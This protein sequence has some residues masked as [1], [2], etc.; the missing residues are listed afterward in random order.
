[1]PRKIYIPLNALDKNAIHW[2]STEHRHQALGYMEQN[3]QCGG[4]RRAMG[5]LT[6][7][8]WTLGEEELRLHPVALHRALVRLWRVWSHPSTTHQTGIRNSQKRGP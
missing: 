7:C 4:G 2:V 3:A 1:M 5:S 8:W 6:H